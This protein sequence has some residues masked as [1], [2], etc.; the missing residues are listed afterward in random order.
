LPWPSPN[1]IAGRESLGSAPE[2]RSKF[3]TIVKKREIK[4]G[5]EPPI[6]LVIMMIYIKANAKS[7]WSD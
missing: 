5:N 1:G 3:Q 6:K 4:F 7:L 2:K